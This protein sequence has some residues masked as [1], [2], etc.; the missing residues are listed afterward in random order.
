[1]RT[2]Y[3]STAV[4]V[5][6]QSLEM[7]TQAG[8][9]GLSDTVLLSVGG[10][11][12]AKT[13]RLSPYLNGAAAAIGIVLFYLGLITLSSDWYNAM[14]QFEKYRWWILS[15]AAGFGIQVALFVWLK[16]QTRKTPLKGA[17]SSLAATGGISSA[18]MAACCAHYLVPIL[19][20]LGLPFLS[21][22]AAGLA[23][24]QSLLFLLGVISNLAGIG[25]MLR[26]MA[27]NGLIPQ[28]V[29]AKYLTIGTQRKN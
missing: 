10:R 11:L 28:G 19:P 3:R 27:K 7:S 8:V 24:Y 23:E 6:E 15:L 17:K 20:V 26:L 25:F 16:K 12:K 14:M 13:S 21:T 18:S 2:Q 22:A 1:M 29:V 9:T 4:N 5:P